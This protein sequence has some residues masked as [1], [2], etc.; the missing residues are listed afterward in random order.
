MINEISI[1]ILELLYLSEIIPIRLQSLI[2]LFPKN[3]KILQPLLTIRK[4]PLRHLCHISHVPNSILHLNQPNPTP[5]P[6]LIKLFLLIFQF[7]I[8]LLQQLELVGFG[9]P[10]NMLGGLGEELAWQYLG[11][12]RV[13]Y[14]WARNRLWESFVYEGGLS[15]RVSLAGLIQLGLVHVQ[16]LSCFA[17]N[18]G[19]VC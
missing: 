2:V 6:L 4:F 3:R 9:Q 7:L 18:I 13:G 1:L 16:P 11:Q 17:I 10:G 8:L 15:G 14:F 19:C 12:G 5:F